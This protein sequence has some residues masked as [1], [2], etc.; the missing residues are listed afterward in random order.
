[1]CN[2]TS[3]VCAW[4]LCVFGGLCDDWYTNGHFCCLTVFDDLYTVGTLLFHLTFVM[5]H[6]VCVMLHVFPVMLQV[7]RVMLHAGVSCNGAR[8]SCNVARVSCNVARV[9][10]NVTGN[11]CYITRN[12]CNITKYVKWNNS[13]PTVYQSSKTVKQ[14]KWP[15]VYQ[16]SHVY[17]ESAEYTKPC[18]TD[19]IHSL[20]KMVNTWQVRSGS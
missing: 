14:Q 15:L 11:T 5:L 10:C 7:F 19:A 1:M 16:S 20:W 18:V 17:K 2:R 13:V 6:V 8:V 4:R 12:T 9:S 3:Y